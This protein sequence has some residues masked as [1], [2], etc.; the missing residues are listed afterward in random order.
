MVDLDEVHVSHFVSGMDL[1]GILPGA[2]RDP[3]LLVKRS[4]DVAGRLPRITGGAVGIVDRMTN[5]AD[6]VELDRATLPAQPSDFG[7]RTPSWV[8]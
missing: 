5:S 8:K 4:P 2:T 3:T 7:H 6:I 1:A